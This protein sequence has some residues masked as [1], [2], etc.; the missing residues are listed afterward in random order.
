MERLSEYGKTSEIIPFDIDS[1]LILFPVR[2]HSPVC[3][4]HLIKTIENYKPDI[5][6]IEGPENADCLIPV[7]T[8]DSTILPAAFYCYYKDSKKLIS[9]DAGDYK[10]YYPFQ[11]SSPEYNA[12][13]QAK[14]LGIT[15]KF[16]DLPYSEILINT[17]ENRGLRK[18]SDKN[19]YTD[20][21]HLTTSKFYKKICEKTGTRS[22]EEFWEKYFEIGGLYI[23]T[24]KFVRQMNTYCILTRADVPEEELISDGTLKRD[25]YMAYNI[26][27]AMQEYKKVLAVTGGF[28]TSGIY[29]LIKKNNIK[30]PKI[31]KIAVNNQGC[32]PMAYSYTACDVLHGYASGM[33]YPYFY[34]SIM[35]KLNKCLSPH[36]IYSEN[37]LDLITL[38]AKKSSEKDVSVTVS[39]II[40]ACSMMN[41]LAALRNSR[42]Y[43]ISE[44]YDA[45][46]ACFI[47]GEKTLSSS[48][49]LDIL[50][51]LAAGDSVGYIGSTEHIPPLIAD[52]EK[53]CKKL[54]IKYKTS[55]PVNIEA[56]LFTSSKGMETSRFM[57][58]MRFLG[59]GFAEM[60][61][62]PDIRSNRDRS[63]VREEWKCRRSPE[64]DSSLIDHTT[65]GFTIEEACSTFAE[66]SLK[67]YQRCETSAGIAVDCFLMG[68][69][70]KKSE[71]I[72]I[73]NTINMDGDFFS[74]GKGLG[75]FETLCGLQNLY[76]FQDDSAEKYL[77]RCFEK[78]VSALPSMAD[79]S[80]EKA[81]DVINI[82]KIMY[83]ITASRLPEKTDVFESALLSLVN[84][85]EKEPA[86]YGAA[87][88]LLST[89][90]PEY[91][92]L[93]ENSAE[94][95]LT[96][97]MEM[98]KKGADYLRGL[99]STAR[100]I[101]FTDSSFLEMTDRL[102]SE[103]ETDDFI[104]VLPSL[105]LAFSNFTPS[106][107]SLVSESVSKLHN[108]SESDLINRTAVDERMF[109]FCEDFDSAVCKEIGKE[110]ALYE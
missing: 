10:C 76:N 52:F 26:V 101:V 54:N 32:Y 89:I 57:H 93:A 70:L 12:A 45:V 71:Q 69:K 91:R 21:S 27:S 18:K 33:M 87:A 23:D 47:K 36:G 41:G 38:T 19:S 84:S 1:P 8:D 48:L 6:L 81:D 83:G 20:D 2:H 34:D 95:Y 37:V 25:E 68:I 50:S 67:T 98:R 105:R 107:I 85:V 13:V 16:I 22:F 3:S 43:G 14:K 96:G 7:L 92:K 80:G 28:H 55:V 78:L 99:F 5:I 62:G 75:Y 77:C 46:T 64:V 79:I 29:N 74:V 100:D 94:G 56:A 82:I 53:Q 11:Y 31:H 104:E 108:V 9:D 39:D 73:D 51:Q 60:I 58:R 24:E 30:K 49:P 61:K 35:K 66:K 110:D 63:R 88:G 4:Y 102:I 109:V 97:S 40:S 15:A 103:F 86:V 42:E 72:L 44:A 65:D 90:N 59:T 106:E 17:A